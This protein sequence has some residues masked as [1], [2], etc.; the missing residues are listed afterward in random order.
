MKWNDMETKFCNY[1]GQ[2]EVYIDSRSVSSVSA[3]FSSFASAAVKYV[4]NTQKQIKSQSKLKHWANRT[5]T[6][7]RN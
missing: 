3:T 1:S 6:H 7:R 5:V 4:T 2:N